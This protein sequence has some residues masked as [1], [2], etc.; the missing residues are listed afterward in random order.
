MPELDGAGHDQGPENEGLEHGHRLGHEQ[1][2]PLGPAI[3][4]DPTKEREEQDRQGLSAP[5][6][7][8]CKAL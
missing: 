5:T 7:P 6:S 8:S 2:A 1:D 4:K 3:G